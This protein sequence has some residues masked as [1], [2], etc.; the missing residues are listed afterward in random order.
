MQEIGGGAAIG[1]PIGIQRDRFVEPIRQYRAGAA[2]A[3]GQKVTADHIVLMDRF[4]KTYIEPCRQLQ[5]PD[6][7][8]SGASDH[9]Q[10]A[11]D[12]SLLA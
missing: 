5:N 11:R 6:R 12:L 10:L 9:H 3:M 8:Y 1:R 7:F 2:K 4:A